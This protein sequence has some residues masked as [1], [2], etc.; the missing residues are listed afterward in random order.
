MS[1]FIKY[2]QDIPG[3]PMSVGNSPIIPGKCDNDCIAFDRNFFGVF[4]FVYIFDHRK[5]NTK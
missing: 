5:S 4:S 1:L 2:R 3:K